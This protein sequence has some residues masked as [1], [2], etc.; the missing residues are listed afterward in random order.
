MSLKDHSSS[1]DPL[2]FIKYMED[3]GRAYRERAVE[4]V[5]ICREFVQLGEESISQ[6]ADLRM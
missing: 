5:S 6:D 4:L 2:S 1:F 3:F